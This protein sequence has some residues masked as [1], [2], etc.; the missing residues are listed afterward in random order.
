MTLSSTST[1]DRK[2][3][4]TT[5]TQSSQS[6]DSPRIL[7]RSSWQTVNIGDIAHTPGMLRMLEMYL[8]TARVT[9]WASHVDNGV[10]EMLQRH[11]PEVNVV[12]G[13]ITGPSQA[14]TTELTKAI[15]QADLLLHGSGPSLVA[16]QDVADWV[17][18]VNKP[19]GAYGIT[20]EQVD[21]ELRSLLNKARFIFLRDS[22]SLKRLRDA[23]I[24]TPILA[25]GP[26]ATFTCDL[27]NDKQAKEFLAEQHL[28]TGRFACFIPRLRYTP[29]FQIHGRKPNTHEQERHT[30]SL[31]R[32]N[33]DHEKLRHAMVQ[34]IRETGCRALVC[35]EMTYQVAL[36]Y[37]QLVAPLPEDV[38]AKVVWR[39]HYWRPD[40]AA[41]VYAQAMAIVSYEMHSPILAAVRGTP[42]IHV[43]QPTDT[44]K[45]QMWRDIGLGEWMFE[46]DETNGDQI[47][48]C[49]LHI[50]A[51]SKTARQSVSQALKQVHQWQR[52]AAA[53]FVS[54]SICQDT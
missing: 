2:I 35:P 21:N 20:V 6:T 27:E 46:I 9:L 38:R 44:C 45:G 43:R 47:T 15:E 42:A 34:F 18:Q 17:E 40:E 11:F 5:Q 33:T 54:T 16:R 32:C 53:H 30:E 8:P 25:F 19:W 24:T 10:R 14:S 31:K 29:Y 36:G 26:D 1:A 50:A 48:E 13:R 52:E 37:E 41:S 51:D 3:A 4:S 39:D 7:L 49:L 28:E 23:N 22:V 12:Q